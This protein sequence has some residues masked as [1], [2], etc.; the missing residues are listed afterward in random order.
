MSR[1][2]NVV[3]IA[4]ESIL[5]V[6]TSEISRLDP[7][8]DENDLYRFDRLKLSITKALKEFKARRNICQEEIS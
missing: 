7:I 1:V 3:I 2:R 5:R 8:N 6:I 4:I